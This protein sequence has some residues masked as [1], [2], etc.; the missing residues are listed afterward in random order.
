[1]KNIKLKKWLI[2]LFSSTHSPNQRLFDCPDYEEM[3]GPRKMSPPKVNSE[4]NC[5]IDGYFS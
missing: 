4:A 2:R 1:M 3:Y 5:K